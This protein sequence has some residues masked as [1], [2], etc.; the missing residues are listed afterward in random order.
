MC[1]F[2]QSNLSTSSGSDKHE[3]SLTLRMALKQLVS[4]M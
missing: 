3:S 2:V 4:L 1:V